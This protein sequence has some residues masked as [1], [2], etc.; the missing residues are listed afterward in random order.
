[1]KKKLNLTAWACFTML[2]PVFAQ[3]INTPAARS[4]YP[5][6]MMLT[7]VW[8]Y[9]LVAGYCQYAAWRYLGMVERGMAASKYSRPSHA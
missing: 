6:L 5:W 8:W 4:G 2:M 1:M 7:G 3:N 9:Y